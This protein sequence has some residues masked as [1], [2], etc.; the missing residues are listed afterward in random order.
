VSGYDHRNGALSGL[1]FVCLEMKAGGTASYFSQA[2]IL[3]S[4][5]QG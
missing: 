1:A 3:Q 5:L 2:S 4:S